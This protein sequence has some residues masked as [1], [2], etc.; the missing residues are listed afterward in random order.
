MAEVHSDASR[1]RNACASGAVEQNAC[2][3]VHPNE[4][5]NHLAVGVPREESR[6]LVARGPVEQ[7]DCVEEQNCREQRVSVQERDSV[8]EG[9]FDEEQDLAEEEDLVGGEFALAQQ[10]EVLVQ[11]ERQVGRI[12]GVLGMSSCGAYYRPFYCPSFG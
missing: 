7:L 2:G 12:A 4:Q 9:D 5:P 8:E 1:A 11:F 6:R 3:L 10:F